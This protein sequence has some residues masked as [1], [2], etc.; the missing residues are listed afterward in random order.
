MINDYL[1]VSFINYEGK[2]RS[3]SDYEVAASL[4]GFAIFVAGE[5]EYPDFDAFCAEAAGANISDSMFAAGRRRETT[6]QLGE[7]RLALEISPFSDGIKF[8]GINDELAPEP[9]FEVNG[10]AMPPLPH[11][12]PEST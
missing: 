2:R 9:A 10:Q 11:S 12:Y 7:T 5:D 8:A 6:F 3:F 1:E 4:N